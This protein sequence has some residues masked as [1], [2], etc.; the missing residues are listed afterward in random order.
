MNTFPWRLGLDPINMSVVNGTGFWL[1]HLRLT[2]D[3][4]PDNEEELDVVAVSTD[5]LSP[6][7]SDMTIASEVLLV[8]LRINNM[9]MKT[10]AL[11]ECESLLFLV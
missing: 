5:L 4:P 1:L 7:R 8:I 10:I 3:G 2:R 6:V 11:V 9:I